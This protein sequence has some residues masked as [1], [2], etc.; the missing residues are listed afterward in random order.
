MLNAG[1]GAFWHSPAVGG[2][3]GSSF[4]EWLIQILDPLPTLL[5]SLPWVFLAVNERCALPVRAHSFTGLKSSSSGFQLVQWATVFLLCLSIVVC[6]S[7]QSFPWQKGSFIAGRCSNRDLK[8]LPWRDLWVWSLPLF[9]SAQKF[10]P[11]LWW[12]AWDL[13][14]RSPDKVT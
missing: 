5:F 9:C 12:V 3:L 2:W 8:P 7:S 11:R 13:Y 10:I 1:W 6:D 4:A 14:I